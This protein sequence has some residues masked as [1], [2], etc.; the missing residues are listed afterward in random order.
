MKVSKLCSLALLSAAIVAGCSQHTETPAALPQG[1]A[2]MMTAY[3]DP[4]TGRFVPT[5]PAGTVLP[6]SKELRDAMSTS[7]EGLTEEPL[8]GGGFKLDLRGRFQSATVATVGADG[9]VTWQCD[10]P[11]GKE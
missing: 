6:L 4:V 5:P 11:D 3:V 8:P 7:H 2:E 10:D 9:T 1:S